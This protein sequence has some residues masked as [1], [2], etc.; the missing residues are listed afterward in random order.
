MV[1]NLIANCVRESGDHG[2]FNSWDRVPYITTVRNGTP[3]IVPAHREIA[4]NF[5][6]ATYASQEAIDTD[7]GSAYYHTHHNFLA[8]GADG[9]KSDFGGHNNL[10]ENNVYAWV[11]SCWGG[12]NDDQFV[13]NTCIANSVSGGFNSDCKKAAGMVVSGNSIYNKAGSLGKTVLCDASNV[14]KG[15]WP[16]AEDVVQMARAVLRFK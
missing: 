7:D 15:K 5:I 2:P 4:R 12:G 1:G 3:S 9:L 8:Y 14:V 16:S 11:G 13:N 6:L 10:H